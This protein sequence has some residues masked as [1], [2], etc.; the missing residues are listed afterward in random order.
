MQQA[1]KKE[2][3]QSGCFLSEQE[4]RQMTKPRQSRRQTALGTQRLVADEATH[5]PTK[6]KKKENET[7]RK[8]KDDAS[9]LPLYVSRHPFNGNIRPD[10]QVGNERSGR[11]GFLPS[12]PSFLQ[13]RSA[14]D[15]AVATASCRYR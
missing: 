3:K 9:R 5:L 14:V 13:A 12:L 15:S 6:Q 11:Q 1:R 2:K 4:S 7:L 8:Q 10:V